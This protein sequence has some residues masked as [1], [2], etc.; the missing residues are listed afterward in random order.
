[1]L[2]VRL[3]LCELDFHPNYSLS[4]SLDA[5]LCGEDLEL[6]APPYF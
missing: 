5:E 1:M 2:A 4:K 3:R 6:L